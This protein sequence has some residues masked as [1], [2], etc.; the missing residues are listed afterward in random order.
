MR[1]IFYSMMLKLMA[2]AFI[3]TSCSGSGDVSGNVYYPYQTERGERWGLLGANGKEFV[4]DEF[5][6]RPCIAVN[7]R[8]IAQNK[9]GQYLVFTAEAKPKQIA[10]PFQAAG[11]F[12]AGVAPV[13]REGKSI[14]F[15][16]KDGK[17]AFEID[18]IN[19]KKVLKVRNFSEGLCLFFTE[20]NLWGAIDASGAVVI[21]ADYTTLDDCKDGK[22]IG[23]HKKYNGK[24][25]S[26]KKLSVIGRD[27]KVLSQISLDKFTPKE[28]Y[29]RNGHL[30]VTIKGGENGDRMGLIDYQGGWILKATNEIREIGEFFGDKF[31][32]YDGEGWGVMNLKGEK[33]VVLSDNRLAVEKGRIVNLDGETILGDDEYLSYVRLPYGGVVAEE[34]QNHWVFIDNDGK[35]LDQLKEFYS[36]DI[37][38]FG[39][40]EVPNLKE[41]KRKIQLEDIFQKSS[42]D[43]DD[44]WMDFNELQNQNNYGF[45]NEESEDIN[46]MLDDITNEIT[47]E[48]SSSLSAKPKAIVVD[49]VNVRLRLSPT[50]DESNILKNNYGMNVH[51]QKGE[52]FPYL[53]EEGEFYRIPYLGKEVYISKQHTYPVYK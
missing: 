7:G 50:L 23:I 35:P 8:F 1:K 41:N 46:D 48:I 45:E 36:I 53:G 28:K 44:T 29:F 12:Y 14:E 30:T 18:K 31:T 34:T 39:S 33:V 13:V 15:I 38:H 17:I 49:G 52:K 32:Y 3:F 26:A 21:P 2:S 37:I 6:E 51:P 9:K 19:K 11:A 47:E 42:M 40:E 4:T 25:T 20:D 27:G 24:E 5:S 16:D 10:G 43:D 22:L